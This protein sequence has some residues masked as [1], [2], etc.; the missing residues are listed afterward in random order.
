[1]L[2]ALGLAWTVRPG[3]P[4]ATSP[5]VTVFAAASLRDVVYEVGAAFSG[6]AE[7]SGRL[8]FNVAGSNVL[9]QQIVASSQADVFL[10]ANE[11][12]MDHVEESGRLVDGS[13]KPILSNRLVVVANASTDWSAT[14]ANDLVRI[15]FKHLSIG[16]PDAVPAGIYAKAFLEKMSYDEGTL[17][18]ALSDRV[19][20]ALDVRAALALVEAD[21]SV[22]GMV[23]R[24]DATESR[25]VRILF[26][27]PRGVAPPIRYF[28]ARVYRP[29]A[30]ATAQQ[31][32][33]FLFSD[34]ARRIFAEHGFEPSAEGGTDE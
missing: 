17:W 24:T 4:V 5:D 30:P 33:D 10:S 20:P 19:A 7:T 14:S 2:V 28:A 18:A 15:P 3:V 11:K 21:P 23:Y 8:Y 34:E 31:F 29:G 12:W 1:M 22:I 13:R 27:L 32:Y 16:N 26:E 6:W 25:L 9:A